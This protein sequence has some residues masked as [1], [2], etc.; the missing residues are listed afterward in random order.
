M[1]PKRKSRQNEAS[2]DTD[3]THPPKRGRRSTES[4]SP[5]SK[6]TKLKGKDRKRKKPKT[7]GT[8]KEEGIAARKEIKSL[9]KANEEKGLRIQELEATIHN[10]SRST[11]ILD[12][13]AIR[14]RFEDLRASVYDWTRNYSS[15]G[16]LDKTIWQ[17]LK[18]HQ[19]ISSSKWLSCR[20]E[21]F[22]DMVHLSFSR[23]LFLNTMLVRFLYDKILLKPF[24]AIPKT[25]SQSTTALGNQ[26]Q[27]LDLRP[28]LQKLAGLFKNSKA[29]NIFNIHLE[30]RLIDDRR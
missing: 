30:Y 28:L 17:P 1:P 20:K 11:H 18:S 23:N 15:D 27:Q 29:Q 16:P 5:K 13:T 3:R 7:K 24:V 10:L 12:D 9:K 19:Y 26:G 14:N 25:F 6:K 4:E 8:L 22:F 21:G 2:D